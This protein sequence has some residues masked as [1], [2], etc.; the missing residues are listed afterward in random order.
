MSPKYYEGYEVRGRGHVKFDATATLST[1]E[2]PLGTVALPDNDRQIGV[3]AW[4][5]TSTITSYTHTP[6]PSSVLPWLRGWQGSQVGGRRGGDLGDLSMRKRQDLFRFCL[7]IFTIKKPPLEY[8]A[9]R[10][11]VI[12]KIRT[13]K[14]TILNLESGFQFEGG[15]L[16]PDTRF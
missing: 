3:G 9:I 6:V 15:F 13:T 4:Y 16:S 1:V 14:V 2:W 12:I 5:V 8:S 11:P 7:F 10:S